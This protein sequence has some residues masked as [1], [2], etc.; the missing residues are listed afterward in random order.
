M[1]QSKPRTLEPVRSS[2]EPTRAE[3]EVDWDA[4]EGRTPEQITRAVR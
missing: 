4:P 2:Y 3:I 1:N